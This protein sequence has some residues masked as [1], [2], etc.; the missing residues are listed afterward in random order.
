MELRGDTLVYTTPK[1][2]RADT[3]ARDR[4]AAWLREYLTTVMTRYRGQIATWEVANEVFAFTATDCV[5]NEKDGN[6]A[7]WVRSLGSGYVEQAFRW[8]RAAD[9]QAKLYYNENR[10]EGLGTKSD[11]VYR[12]AKDL[13]DR[14]VPIDGVGMQ[15]HFIVAE[16]K[17]DPWLLPP[18]LADV[19]ANMKRLGD[20]GLQVQVTEIDVQVGKDPSSSTLAAQAQLFAGMVRTCLAAPSCTTVTTWGVSDRYSWIR[21]PSQ[22]KAY[23]QPLL[24]DD[25]FRPKPA[26]DAVAGVLDR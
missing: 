20:L 15:S 4:L 11:C 18:P 9:P 3:F 22:N 13:R 23:E 5:P 16:A 25:S 19:A 6:S 2:L 10:A 26:Y 1:W 21:S 14:A 24:V 7:F 17:R 8:A 12:L